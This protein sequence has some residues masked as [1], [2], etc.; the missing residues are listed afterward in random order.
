MA[1]DIQGLLQK[2]HEEG[3]KK[4][5]AEKE[6]IVADAKAQADSILK[7]ARE[8]ADSI[9]KKAEEE[10]SGSE[11]RA[12]AAI[13]QAAR[14]IILTLK[15]DLM[16]RL[17]KVM[18]GAVDQAMTAELMGKIL[19]EMVRNYKEKNIG[20][21]P[22]LDILLNAKDLASLEGAL[23]SSLAAE[24]RKNPVISAGSDFGS[25][26]K[27]GFKGSDVFFDFSDDALT[28]IISHYIGPRVAAMLND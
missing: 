18:K 3:L 24:L 5:D 6:K 11:A 20:A 8:E 13:K 23:K 19:L 26:L 2:I 7:K 4:A 25:G 9:V 15:D 12:K 21:D 17:D 1:E 14:D 27:I 22:E 10:A 16:K 28:E